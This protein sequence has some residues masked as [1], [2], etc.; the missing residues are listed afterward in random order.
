MNKKLE[1]F[2]LAI[3]AILLAA[4]LLVMAWQNYVIN[5]KEIL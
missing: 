2:L 3:I 5:I 4:V 1:S